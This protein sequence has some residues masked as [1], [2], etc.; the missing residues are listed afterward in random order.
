MREDLGPEDGHDLLL[1][2]EEAGRS[3]LVADF[4]D[5]CLNNE[6]WDEEDHPEDLESQDG[7]EHFGMTKELLLHVFPSSCLVVGRELPSRESLSL[8]TAIFKTDNYITKMHFC[9]E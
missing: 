4:P 2:T 5:L 7:L 3:R 8:P 6:S 1:V 9:Q